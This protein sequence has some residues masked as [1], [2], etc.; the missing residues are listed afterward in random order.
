MNYRLLKY[1]KERPSKVE[2]TRSRPYQKNDNAHVEQKNWSLVRRVI[3]YGRYNS[4]AALERLNMVYAILR[5]YV[6][7]FQPT[8]K[9]ISKTRHG[10]KVHKIYDIA[11][12]PY[13]RLLESG[14]LTPAKQSE[15]AAIYKG[16]NPVQLL[17][18]LNGHLTHLWKLAERPQKARGETIS[19]TGTFESTKAV[20]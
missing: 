2:F 11:K 5:Q 17:R 14:V 6:N 18:Q 9:L 13:Q 7:F 10:A 16:L 12:T 15:L 8:M 4:H 20:R 19:V 1:F 3:G